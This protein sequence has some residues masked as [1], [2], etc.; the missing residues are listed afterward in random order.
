MLCSGLARVLCMDM[1]CTYMV[2]QVFKELITVRSVFFTMMMMMNGGSLYIY[3]YLAKVIQFQKSTKKAMAYSNIHNIYI[4]EM[5]KI[6]LA[7]SGASVSYCAIS[8]YI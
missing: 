8:S 5:C 2:L 1:C 3:V 7:T 4:I 6:E